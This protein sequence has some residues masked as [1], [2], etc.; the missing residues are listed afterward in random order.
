MRAFA[1]WI[2]IAMAARAGQ[3]KEVDLVVWVHSGNEKAT[4]VG[5]AESR[6]SR[7]LERAGIRAAWR[8]GKADG[9]EVVFTRPEDDF[10]P[11][12]L[13][14]ADLSRRRIEVFFERVAEGRNESE[15]AGV[16]A[17]VLVHEIT[18]L[19]EGVGR[20]AAVGIMK[21]HWEVEDYRAMR[22]RGLSFT[23]EDLR[24]LRAWA[25]RREAQKAD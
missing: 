20:H 24:M 16:L 15:V 18:H 14:Y 6:A 22:T 8:S 17:H 23:G 12:A 19:L 9:I 25:E 21:A 10:K 4:L 7:I 2:L 5:M 11:G 13:A 1:V 3:R